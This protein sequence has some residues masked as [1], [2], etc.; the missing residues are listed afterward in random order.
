MRFSVVVIM[1][2]PQPWR[3]A[4]RDGC[5]K[6]TLHQAACCNH[7]GERLPDC[8][9]KL[10]M[11][12]LLADRLEPPFGRPIL[13]CDAT[14]SSGLSSTRASARCAG[15]G[16]LVLQNTLLHKPDDIRAAFVSR[17]LFC[18]QRDVFHATLYRKFCGMAGSDSCSQ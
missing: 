7:H 9:R 16:F 5:G 6:A 12:V 4:Q 13:L 18:H 14:A 1:T 17:L 11:V 10:H 15:S 8:V 3:D 2:S